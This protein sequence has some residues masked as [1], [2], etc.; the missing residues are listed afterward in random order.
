MPR[1]R[2]FGVRPT[3]RED[4][5][6]PTPTVAL[7]ITQPPAQAQVGQLP[8]PIF[9]PSRI[10][11]PNIEVN[12]TIHSPESQSGTDMSMPLERATSSEPPAGPPS[13]APDARDPGGDETNEWSS[14]DGS[15]DPSLRCL[16]G[17]SDNDMDSDSDHSPIFLE[18][19]SQRGNEVLDSDDSAYVHELRRELT[20]HRDLLGHNP[21]SRYRDHESSSDR[22]SSRPSMDSD[23]QSDSDAVATAF[24]HGGRRR[25]AESRRRQLQD[26]VASVNEIER[27]SGSSE[28]QRVPGDAPPYYDFSISGNNARS[29]RLNRRSVRRSVRPSRPSPDTLTSFISQ[30]LVPLMPEHPLYPG[31]VTTCPICYDAY[32]SGHPP[33][34]IDNVVGCRNHIFGYQCLRKAISS[35]AKNANCCPL[36]RTTWFQMR[37]MELRRVNREWEA[38]ERNEDELLGEGGARVKT[39]DIGAAVRNL[40]ALGLRLVG[41]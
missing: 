30:H 17:D 24:Y 26:L 40:V 33:I 13:S 11:L 15:E 34:L 21:F 8:L 1:R 2:V 20:R 9:N 35:G 22:S 27:S 16:F 38:V 3:P 29:V 10:R 18:E 41:W 28:A 7:P 32:H 37:R 36:C 6:P 25:A 23:E 39:F 19:D 12:S 5:P 14:T 4:A 31:V